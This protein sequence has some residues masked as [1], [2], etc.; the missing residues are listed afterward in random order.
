M[1]NRPLASC[2]SAFLVAVL[3]F[4]SPIPVAAALEAPIPITPSLGSISLGRHLHILEDRDGVLT[5]E[6]VLSPEMSPRFVRSTYD[7]PGFGFTPSVY[8]A[9]FTVA[10]PGDSP[11]PWF[12]EL[13]YPLIDHVALYTPRPD[14]TLDVRKF[15]DRLPF[16]E[17]P[18]DYRNLVIPLSEEAGS[19]RTYL[20]RFESSSSMNLSLNAWDPRRFFEA[21]LREEI[22]LGISYGALLIMSIYNAVQ[23]LVFRD[24]GHLFYVLFFATWG[25]TQFAINGLAFQLLWPTATWWANVCIPAFIFAALY[26]FIEWGRTSLS[27]EKVV[28]RIDRWFRLSKPLLLL[29]MVGSLATP[30][31]LS[32]RVA[33]ASAALTA[34]SWALAAAWCS[35]QG[36]RSA[37]FFLIALGLYFLGTILFS[38][39]SLGFMS[40]NVLTN[41]GIQVGGFAALI[42]FSLST[43]DKEL[44]VLQ[45]SETRLA[46]EVRERTRE[47]EIEK[48]KSEAAN[49][50]KGRFLAYVSPEI[51]TP[52]NGILGMA[53]LLADTRL[54]REQRDY[55]DTIC[56]SGESL[57][58]IVNDILDVSKLDADQL[59]L[60]SVPFR[61]VDVVEP[62]L[63]V[64][65]PLARKK[66]LDLI[67][68]IDPALPPVLVG[69]GHR[70]TQ[71]LLNLVSNAIK[72]TR[73]GSVTIRAVRAAGGDGEVGV[74]FSVTDTGPGIP[75]ERQQKLFSAYEQGAAEVARL[76]GGT[77]LGL[78]I[79]RQLVRLM[80]GDIG[81]HSVEG[82]GS[83]FHF[84]I[85]LPVGEA[86]ALD[87]VE[88]ADALPIA[89][90]EAGP[91]LRI[92]QI[93]DVATNRAVLEGILT[94]AGHAVV[95]VTNGRE[96]LEMLE[97]TDNRF[98]AIVSDRHMPEMDGIRATRRI[99]QLGPPFDTIPIVGVTASVVEFEMQECLNAG[100]NAVLPKP[101]DPRRLLSTLAALHGSCGLPPAAGEKPRLLV[102]DDVAS[103]LAVARSQLARLG[104]DCDTFDSSRAALTAAATQSYA[105]I[106]VDLSMPV[107]DGVAF[108]REIRTRE[109]G[110][111][112][113]TPVLILTGHSVEDA[114]RMLDGSGIDDCLQKPV[115]LASLGSALR[116]LGVGSAPKENGKPAGSVVTAERSG[117]PIDRAKLA[118]V[119]GTEDE[120]VLRHILGIFLGEFPTSLGEVESAMAAGDRA[121]LREAAHAAKGAAASAAATGL[122]AILQDLE[123]EAPSADW[124][125]LGLLRAQGV[126]EFRWVLRFCEGGGHGDAAASARGPAEDAAR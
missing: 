32:I 26:S 58:R 120:E 46:E 76:Y 63:S 17:R 8:W 43:T 98:D 112:T 68:E 102:V 101:V 79:C 66:N 71:V 56:A 93:E 111:P 47:L 105:A 78:A 90:E 11:V 6:Q 109:N 42:L 29:G 19:S 57:V 108:T 87:G 80:G 64:M 36:Q 20:M 30:Y 52:M 94:R 125:R 9:K 89:A 104:F 82:S 70:L 91:R 51:R 75:V 48:E 83:T 81:V 62:V 38:L 50:A 115:T 53:W 1:K 100:M 27:T 118:R 3:A 77:G 35:K 45:L 21:A 114:R 49:A 55:A 107:V 99:R 22:V 110:G 2:R 74:H 67:H 122:A 37:R 88:P 69:D 16:A 84:D 72:F 14:G 31:S 103:N 25:L 28:P 73:Q 65:E 95:S 4:A 40:G 126:E 86:T 61:M 44:Q 113:R 97:G 54:D 59:V 13:D 15:G 12:L 5:A 39:K 7:E 85:R 116:R 24:R 60:E 121:A 96:A 10:N 124:S 33:T 123:S 92:L 23:F 18:L 41:W 106:L 34:A 119:L 117:V